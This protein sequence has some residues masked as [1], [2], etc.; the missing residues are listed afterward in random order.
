MKHAIEAVVIGCSAGGLKSLCTIITQLP[1]DY[2][3]PDIVV[4][5]RKEGSDDFLST[6]LDGQSAIFVKE[7]D[8]KEEIKAAT[9]YIAPPGYHLLVEQS[10]TFSLSMEPLVNFTRPAIDVLFET[11][12]DVYE[13]H[14]LGLLLTGANSDGSIGLKRIQQYGGLTVAQNPQTAEAQQMPLA[15]THL[16]QVDYVLELE[17]IGKFLCQL[18]TDELGIKQLYDHKS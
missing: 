11:A 1:V 15:A 8:E 7:A 9:V 16:L 6:Y 4:Q 12:A 18:V 10:H 14:L 3:H 5:H 2:P 13:E 17:E